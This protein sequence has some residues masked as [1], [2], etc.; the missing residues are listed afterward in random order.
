MD[1]PGRAFFGGIVFVTKR[2]GLTGIKIGSS[3]RPQYTYT[4]ISAETRTSSRHLDTGAILE[5]ASMFRERL[6]CTGILGAV[7]MKVTI[8]YAFCV[9]ALG[10][11]VG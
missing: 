4:D 5:I 8:G 7:G 3:H 1:C 9:L 6:E 10:E 11:K 2:S